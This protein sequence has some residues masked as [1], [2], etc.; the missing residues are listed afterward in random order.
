[1]K[2]SDVRALDEKGLNTRLDDLKKDLFF[3]RMKASLGQL[4]NV[5]EIRK[6]KK[7][8]GQVLTV[9]TEVKKSGKGAA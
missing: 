9:M 7:Q 1:M 4:G 3:L 8:I 6:V 2:M 5:R